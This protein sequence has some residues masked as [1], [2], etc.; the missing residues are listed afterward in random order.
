MAKVRMFVSE[1]QAFAASARASQAGL[2]MLSGVAGALEL[3]SAE[4]GRLQRKLLRKQV[5]LALA[6]AGAVIL[7][8]HGMVHTMA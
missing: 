1:W 4:R 7:F 6:S 3:R 2:P 5:G 8:L